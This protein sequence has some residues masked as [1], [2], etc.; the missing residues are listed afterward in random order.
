M[1]CLTS[2]NG[3]AT[4][5]AAAARPIAATLASASLML[6]SIARAVPQRGIGRLS[7]QSEPYLEDAPRR[8]QV[9]A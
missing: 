3:A 2:S 8:T 5:A 7:R 9:P 6:A 4:P 1:A